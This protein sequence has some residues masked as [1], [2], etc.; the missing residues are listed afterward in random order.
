MQP[1]PGAALLAPD[2]PSVIGS[3]RAG[4]PRVAERREHFPHRDIA[5]ARRMRRLVAFHAARRRS[6]VRVPMLG[7]AASRVQRSLSLSAESNVHR[8]PSLN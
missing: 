1:V 5:E 7:R 4:E 3:H 8:A 6:D 2:H